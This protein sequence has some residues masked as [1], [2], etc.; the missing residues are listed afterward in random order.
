MKAL[1]ILFLTC[2]HISII[3]YSEEIYEHSASKKQYLF[4]GELD[5]EMNPSVLD[6]E[7]QKI[8]FADK[9]TLQQIDRLKPGEFLKEIETSN[10][11]FSLEGESPNWEINLNPRESIIYYKEHQDKVKIDLD[12][13]PI[14]NVFVLMFKSENADIYG[15]I[16][17][18]W[19]N[20]ACEITL[21]DTTSTFEVFVNIKGKPYKG[22]A[23]IKQQS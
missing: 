3:S 17:K 10:L 12:P 5:D 6:M 9:S 1:I 22:C 20:T 21:N 8:I 16:R 23:Y 11:Y 7:T 19:G 13:H 15:V 4:L 18:L 14:D 2:S